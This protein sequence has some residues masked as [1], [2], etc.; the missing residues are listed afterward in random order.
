MASL[1]VTNDNDDCEQKLASLAVTN[2]DDDF[3]QRK[4]SAILMLRDGNGDKLNGEPLLLGKVLEFISDDAKTF[5]HF[6]LSSRVKQFDKQELHQQCESILLH[7]HME[8]IANVKKKYEGEEY[9]P[10][11]QTANDGELNDVRILLTEEG[12]DIRW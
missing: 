9:P 6:I 10:F 5:Y 3:E 8:M 2:N 12:M 1:A 7:L 4:T 11:I